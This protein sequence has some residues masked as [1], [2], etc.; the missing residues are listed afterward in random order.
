MR[1]SSCLAG[2]FL[3]LV[4]C[5]GSDDTSPTTPDV[6]LEDS[7]TSAQDAVDVQVPQDDVAA[8]DILEADVPAPDV[9]D[10]ADV[11]EEVNDAADVAEPLEDIAPE[12]IIVPPADV[13]EEDT[14]VPP[15]DVDV[16]DPCDPDPCQN[17]GFCLSIGSG[18]F[19]S[20]PPGFDGE[21]CEEANDPCDPNPCLNGGSCSAFG[22]EAYCSCIPDWR[23]EFC[24]TCGVDC[25]ERPDY[26][27][28]RYLLCI[29]DRPFCEGR[30]ISCEEFCSGWMGCQG[31]IA[32]D[33]DGI[34][35]VVGPDSEC[36]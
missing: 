31:E 36:F 14:F 2:L 9:Q 22:P 12:D 32:I 26:Y 10:V 18:F 19:C 24:E 33:A 25:S 4:A 15:A 35:T 3:L 34:G 20:C 13:V 27:R 11:Q 16:P 7:D 29:R 30:P 6:Q 17:G 8:E 1:A 28:D 21:F 23:G 5:S